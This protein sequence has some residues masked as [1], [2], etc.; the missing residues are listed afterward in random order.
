MKRKLIGTGIGLS[1]FAGVFGANTVPQDMKYLQGGQFS[2]TDPAIIG[3]TT[4]P[5]AFTDDD[6]DGFVSYEMY[7]DSKGNRVFEKIS[8]KL[9]WDISRT[10]RGDLLVPTKTELVPLGNVIL[11]AITP[12]A[13][14]A[15]A[16][17]QASKATRVN[18]TSIS[19]ACA[20]SGSNGLALML[21]GDNNASNLNEWKSITVNT[22]ATTSNSFIDRSQLPSGGQGNMAVYAFFAPT[23]GTCT[24]TIGG[25]TNHVLDGMVSSY[26]GVIQSGSWN[27]DPN[28]VLAAYQNATTSVAGTTFTLTTNPCAANSW[29][30]MADQNDTAGANTAAGTNYTTRTSDAAGANAIGDTNGTVSGSTAMSTTTTASSNWE[31]IQVSIAPVGATCGGVAA[32][33]VPPR[34]LINTPVYIGEGRVIFN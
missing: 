28:S 8:D 30:F 29:L 33:V 34:M 13:H 26:S 11:G 4:L 31:G 7:E 20:F 14:A 9:Y 23:T 27:K 1:L 3:T 24:A 25:V 32:P 18:N 5:Y 16:F 17:D 21:V 12:K 22:I 15:I 6:G 2:A 10:N 19:W